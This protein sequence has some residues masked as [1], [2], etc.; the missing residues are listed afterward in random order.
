MKR[1]KYIKLFD[2]YSINESSS[3]FLNYASQ[4]SS[5]PNIY[6][7]YSNIE[8]PSLNKFSCQVG[9]LIISYDDTTKREYE[10][11]QV[12]TTTIKVWM[13]ESLTKEQ[14]MNPEN[15][16][17][18][19]DDIFEK[20]PG[21]I[22]TAENKKRDAAAKEIAQSKAKMEIDAA[23]GYEEPGVTKTMYQFYTPQGNLNDYRWVKISQTGD[24][25]DCYKDNSNIS[26][27]IFKIKKELKSKIV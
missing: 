2:S 4:K 1:L 8:D 9:N 14:V 16:G 21:Y 23:G 6:P 27:L 25:I 17:V 11:K 18:E 3:G 5:S 22:Q 26:D 13:G 24:L 10:N 7:S 15:S 20:M 12:P 19:P